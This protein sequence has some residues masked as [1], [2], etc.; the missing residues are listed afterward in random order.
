MAR[1]AAALRQLEAHRSSNGRSSID[2]KTVWFRKKSTAG[3][4]SREKYLKRQ[5]AAA[6]V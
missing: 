2:L 1:P 6:G 5:T 3:W 4:P